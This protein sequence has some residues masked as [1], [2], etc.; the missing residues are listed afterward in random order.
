MQGSFKQLSVWIHTRKL[1]GYN[2]VSHCNAI[3]TF[4]V[5]YIYINIA[6]ARINEMKLP[7]D[8][9]NGNSLEYYLCKMMF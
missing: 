1:R 6:G 3:R 2:N 9:N 5:G 4:S 8:N 7:I